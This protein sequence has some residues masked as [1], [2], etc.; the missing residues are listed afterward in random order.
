MSKLIILTREKFLSDT[1]QIIDNISDK[2]IIICTYRSQYEYVKKK[3]KKSNILLLKLFF[4]I[5]ILNII[6]NKFLKK[7]VLKFLLNTIISKYLELKFTKIINNFKIL[8]VYIDDSFYNP[9]T[10]SIKNLK[11][12]NKISLN[13]LYFYEHNDEKYTIIRN[14]YVYK[15]NIFNNFFFKILI[16]LKNNNNFILSNNKFYF[17]RFTHLQI[18]TI[19]LFKIE[20]G[21]SF[22]R[23]NHSFFDNIYCTDFNIKENLQRKKYLK[24][25]NIFVFKNKI[26]IKCTRYKFDFLITTH[27]FYNHKQIVNKYDDLNIYNILI[28]TLKKITNKIVLY[29]HPNHLNEEK[30]EIV[31][32]AKQNNIKYKIGG[33]FHEDVNN[34]KIVLTHFKSTIVEICNKLNIPNLKYTLMFEKINITTHRYNSKFIKN[35]SNFLTKADVSQN[36]VLFII[37][38][39]KLFSNHKNRLAY[40]FNK[41]LINN[42]I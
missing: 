30:L 4:F 16:N 5:N 6:N 32:L 27:P 24:K 11:L 31:K 22:E 17:S 42:L 40:K 39:K 20:V 7:S 34:S 37:A 23:I 33:N 28:K 8:S 29:I 25:S 36:K 35:P 3:F 9:Y 26:K 1:T 12:H 10:I 18:L 38:K 19:L 2:K 21:K 15:K 41:K 14:S 13:L